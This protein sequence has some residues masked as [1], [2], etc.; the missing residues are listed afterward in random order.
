MAENISETDVTT[1]KRSRKTKIVLLIVLILVGLICVEVVYFYSF[2]RPFKALNAMAVIEPDVYSPDVDYRKV[3]YRSQIKQLLPAQ[4]NGLREILAALGPKCLLQPDAACTIPWEDFPTNEDSKI[5]F[6]KMWTP[7]CEIFELDPNAKPSML[8]RLSLDDYLIKNGITGEETSP[9]AGKPASETSAEPVGGGTYWEN[10][11]ELRGVIGIDELEKVYKRLLSSPWTAEEFPVVAQWIEENDDYYDLI[12]QA[13]RK[14]KFGYLH[15]VSSEPMWNMILP[16][17]PHLREFAGMLRLRANYRLGAGDVSGALDDVESITLIVDSVFRDENSSMIQ[18]LHAI[19]IGTTAF[20]VSLEGSDGAGPTVEECQRVVELYAKYA[21]DETS[22]QL[23]DRS[24]KMQKFVMMNTISSLL[25]ERRRK[26]RF[27]LPFLATPINDDEVLLRINELSDKYLDEATRPE[28]EELI[29]K[30]DDFGFD[31]VVTMRWTS[32]SDIADVFAAQFMGALSTFESAVQLFETS[33]RLKQIAAATLAYEADHGTLPPAFSV[34]ADGQPLLSWRVLILPYLGADA[35]ALYEEFALDEPWDSEHNQPL[36]EKIPDVYRR[37]S[38]SE[39]GMTRIAA[40]LGEESFFDDS[41]VGKKRDEAILAEGGNPDDLAL[42][43]T[44]ATLVPW[45]SPDSNLD[46]SALREALAASRKP[47]SEAS[48][49]PL[50]FLAPTDP[51]GN[52]YATA[53]GAVKFLP[54][55]KAGPFRFLERP[56]YGHFLDEE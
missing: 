48:V 27:L 55:F 44:S 32:G 11:Q 23:F 47:N 5:W 2:D 34:D 6:E 25:A 38:D 31:E 13:V 30:N 3:Y 33:A 37:P 51:T 24:L 39:P 10:Q 16:E 41:G 22:Q 35:Q 8:D 7:Y 46:Q 21:Q 17:A 40:L 36:L 53:N 54:L 45:T 42:F 49:G 26:V 28:V 56:L 4:E 29:Q 19:I 50:A 18:S 20:G 9:D 52:V 14:P 43:M 1:P 15:S 12:S